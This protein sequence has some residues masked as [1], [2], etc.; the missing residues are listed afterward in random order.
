[1]GIDWNDKHSY[2]AWRITH[3]LKKQGLRPV[4]REKWEVHDSV[5]AGYAATPANPQQTYCIAIRPGRGIFEIDDLSSWANLNQ[6]R[7][8]VLRQPRQPQVPQRHEAI[9]V[10]G[11]LED[12][13]YQV[14]LGKRDFIFRIETD[15]KTGVQ[16]LAKA[17][18][19]GSRTYY[20]L[21]RVQDGVLLPSN[22]QWRDP[23]YGAAVDEAAALL[24]AGEDAVREAA[25]KLYARSFG[26]CYV[27]NRP[28]TVADSLATG[29]GPD[30]AGTRAHHEF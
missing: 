14:I 21:G 9:A 2:D 28:L 19:F 12:G 8:L 29:I 13:F 7:K 30:C 17:H 25:G 1:M 5:Y 20:T 27:C 10:G 3:F 24:I 6:A 4:D 16:T 11:K 15:K 22:I 18:K 23:D 26:R